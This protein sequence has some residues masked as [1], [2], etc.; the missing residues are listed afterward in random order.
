MYG[1]LTGL[2]EKFPQYQK[3]PFYITG[4]SY[5][6][7]YIPAVGHKIWEM[8]KQSPKTKINLKGLAIGNGMTDPEEQYKHYPEMG[9]DGGKSQGGS[10]EKGVITNPVTQAIMR[11]GVGPCVKAIQSCNAGSTAGCMGAF[12]VAPIGQLW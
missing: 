11:G 4:E 2:L 12:M 6:G 8:N 9:F 7:H 5:A 10:L 3:L 1:F